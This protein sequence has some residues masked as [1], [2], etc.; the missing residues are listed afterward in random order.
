[1][2]ISDFSFHSIGVLLFHLKRHEVFGQ[3][4]QDIVVSGAAEI[5]ALGGDDMEAVVETSQRFGLD[6]DDAYQYTAAR[7]RDMTLVS[8]DTDFDRTDLKRITPAECI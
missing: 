3:F 1:M 4:V 7:K 5:V 8:F 6:F 2:F